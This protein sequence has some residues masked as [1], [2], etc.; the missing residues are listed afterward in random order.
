[1]SS[2]STPASFPPLTGKKSVPHHM[3]FTK[4]AMMSS[5]SP[6]FFNPAIRHSP[7]PY[8]AGAPPGG[9][10]EESVMI[11]SGS[12]GRGWHV[13]EKVAEC[14]FGEVLRAMDTLHGGS[15]AIKQMSLE[16]ISRRA[17]HNSE[18]P[19]KEISALQFLKAHGPLHNII[20]VVE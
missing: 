6:P 13:I 16:M 1:S 18:D 8:I 11:A 2:I 3:F 19:L 4:M 5:F 14:L 15:Y 9:S 12:S 7:S 10:M 20:E 17:G